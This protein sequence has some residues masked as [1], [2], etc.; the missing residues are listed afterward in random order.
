MNQQS[1]VHLAE[2]HSHI[3]LLLLRERC[4]H[5]LPEPVEM[6]ADDPANL[7]VTR[8]PCQGCGGFRPVA[9]GMLAS[10]DT[11]SACS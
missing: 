5:V 8:C 7:F 1:A 2:G 4:G 10:G 9:L 11:P 3:V 6:L